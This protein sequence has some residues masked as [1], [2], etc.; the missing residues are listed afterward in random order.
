MLKKYLVIVAVI[1]FAAAG[2]YWYWQSKR[3]VDVKL[4]LSILKSEEMNFLVTRR[5]ASTVVLEKRENDFLLGSRHGLLIAD[6]ELL[7][8]FDLNKLAA[9]SLRADGDTVTVTL[10]EPE[11]LRTVVD[12]NSMR[13]FTKQSALSMLSDKLT[14]KDLRD[15]LRKEFALAARDRFRKKE[16]LP[17]RKELKKSLETWAVPF[18]AESG[19]KVRFE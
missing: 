9:A 8:G 4:A 19:I 3:T 2:G 13:Y 6:V 11:I 14:D 5:L 1:S 12:M 18:F 15:E 7:C 17:S 16:L 10:P